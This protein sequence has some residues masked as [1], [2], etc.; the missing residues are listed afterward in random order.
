M[1]E[2]NE[3]LDA[4]KRTY[5]L[6]ISQAGYR[7]HDP[8]LDWMPDP[9]SRWQALDRGDDTDGSALKAAD[10]IGGVATIGRTDGPHPGV[11][12]DMEGNQ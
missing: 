4:I 8:I 9:P 7:P 3:L 2:R 6:L 5:D 11:N 10:A 1:T 12:L